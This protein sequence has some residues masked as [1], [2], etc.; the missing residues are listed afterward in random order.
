M[1]KNQKILIVDDMKDVRSTL[2]GVLADLGH[3]VRTVETEAETLLVVSE[4]FFDFIVIDVRLKG[5]DFEDESGVELTGRIR[6]LGIDSQ[7]ILVTGQ[8][9]RGS[10]LNMQKNIV[11]LSMLKKR[12]LD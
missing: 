3:F 4:E 10:T 6:A 7:I 8:A 11:F 5:H 12:E 1:S 9:V 2:A